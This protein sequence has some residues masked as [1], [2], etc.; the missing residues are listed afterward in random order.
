MKPKDGSTNGAKQ[1]SSSSESLYTREQVD[2][3]L[4][5]QKDTEIEKTL[6]RIESTQKW[7]LGLMGTG[8][9]SLL[10]LMAHGFRWIV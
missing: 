5:M 1:M 8:F 9:F 3:E 6:E 10:G 4:L 7:M 2:I